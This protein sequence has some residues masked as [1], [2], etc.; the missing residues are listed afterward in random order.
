MHAREPL[1]VLHSRTGKVSTDM[2]FFEIR[3]VQC[4]AQQG[5]IS[6]NRQLTII[7]DFDAVYT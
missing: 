2:G 4:L 3:F 1:Q 5:S 6:S 7:Y